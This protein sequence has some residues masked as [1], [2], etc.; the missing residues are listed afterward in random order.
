MRLRDPK[1]WFGAV[2]LTLV[3]LVFFLDFGRTSPGPLSASH[4]AV[5]ELA[6]ARGCDACHGGWLDSMGDSCLGCH[7]EIQE[8]FDGRSGLHGEH[9][10]ARMGADGAAR[11]AT[12]HGEHLG[13]ELDPVG[14]LAFTL[15][16]F[17]GRATFDHGHVEFDLHGKHDGLACVECHLDAESA[18]LAAGQTRFL[19]L[20]STCTGCHE[21][22]HE[23][24]FARGCETCHGQELPFAE[25]ES[26]EHGDSFPLRG[27][28]GRAACSDCHV[29]DGPH[30]VEAL[31][32]HGAPPAARAC[33]D[34]HDSPHTAG[35]TD[36]AG[37]LLALSAGASC[38]GCHDAERGPFEHDIEAF[39]PRFHAASGF[40]LEEP[41]ANLDCGACH[42]GGP[43][44]GFRARFPGR[45][46]DDCAACHDDPHGGQFQ[47]ALADARACV[48]CHGTR[49]FTPVNFGVQEH[50][51]TSFPLEESHAS[52]A[53]NACH[54]PADDTR[55]FRGTARA[56]DAC[57]A[58]PHELTLAAG[59]A[60]P[61]AMTGAR[62]ASCEDCHA[63]SLF[64]EVDRAAFEHEAWTGFELDGAHA[65]VDCA[66]CHP[67]KA[68]PE[69]DGRTFGRA[70]EVFAGPLGRCATCHAD[71]HLGAFDPGRLPA[72]AEPGGCERCHVAS[73][74]AHGAAASFDHGAWTGFAL[75]GAHARAD[76]ERCHGEGP[77]AW[78][79]PVP[80]TRSLGF[81]AGRD[82]AGGLACDVCH[83]DPHG[84]RFELGGSG[85]RA[86]CGRCH[87]E[88]SFA[89][90]RSEVFDHGRETGHELLGRHAEASCVACH[91]P[92]RGASEG[93]VRLGRALGTRCAS[94]HEDP[95]AGQFASGGRTSC[96]D[97]HL[98]QAPA[99]T[100]L[101]FD[102]GV[103]ARFALDARHADLA[104]S[105]CHVPWPLADGREVVR[106]KPLGTECIDC[107][108]HGGGK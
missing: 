93:A 91:V 16:G 27:A 34:C 12:C 6:D 98:E 100:E 99:F 10:T 76:C 102:H 31:A 62:G 19:G 2:S 68:R 103:D 25:L 53:C 23:G 7:A 85:P 17:S 39:E 88:E 86:S 42:G 43:E 1:L 64:S 29:P 46:A 69:H 22:P 8:Q 107:H 36:A 81:V 63:T 20:T 84:G 15:A 33:L 40:A 13:T 78:G 41:H 94:C 3:L 90:V 60:A 47:D 9:L 30:S 74:F 61:V 58:D 92:G 101:D 24:R 59:P 21:D 79:G 106:Y 45:R 37:E 49:A 80:A 54:L 50:A 89:E 108:V 14:E 70:A 82:T 11:C 38:E 67:A 28:H 44:R 73:S 32:G 95:H 77:A 104:C 51:R 26:F 96:A 75:A 66:A 71:A 57:H 35:F 18:V 65:Q 56:C 83:V 105:A 97:C 87:T 55:V 4:A 52:V 72:G 48:D 5:A